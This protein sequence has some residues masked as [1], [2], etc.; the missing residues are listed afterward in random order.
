MDVTVPAEWSPHKVMWLGFPSHAEL[1]K[2]DLEPAQAE[3]AA[4]ARALAGPG[5]E[6]VRLLTG[7][8]EGEAAARAIL[9]DEAN[10]EIVPGACSATSGCATPARS[11]PAG[12]GPPPSASTAG[13][14]S[15]RWSTTTPW[16]GRSRGLG[17]A[18]DPHDFILEG[19]SRWTTT[20][21]ARS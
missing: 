10:I 2:E 17:R 8:P 4:L 3:V 6:T 7:S 1:W 9:G 13:A 14:A 18:P 20:V 19:G 11:S 15:T 5:G 21:W 12:S 16:P